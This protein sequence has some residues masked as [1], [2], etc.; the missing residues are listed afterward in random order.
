MARRVVED[1]AL[2]LHWARYADKLLDNGR[3]ASE[4]RTL[5]KIKAALPPEELVVLLLTPA[6]AG[7]R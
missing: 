1:R 7:P 2:P 3:N 4:E 5:L 6:S